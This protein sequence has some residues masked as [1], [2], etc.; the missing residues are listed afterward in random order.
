MLVKLLFSSN[1]AVLLP[2]SGIF[3]IIFVLID[4]ELLDPA[5]SILVGASQC[6]RVDF[7]AAG[8]LVVVFFFV[9]V[10]LVIVLILLF[11]LHCGNQPLLIHHYTLDL[12]CCKHAL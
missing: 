7:V 12:S 6:L 9:V 5:N 8:A 4:G 2:S 10:F 11:L 3:F 1:L